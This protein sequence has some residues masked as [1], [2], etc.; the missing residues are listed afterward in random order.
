LQIEAEMIKAGR[1]RG[2]DLGRSVAPIQAKSRKAAAD[3]TGSSPVKPNEKPMCLTAANQK[4]ETSCL[5]SGFEECPATSRSR[6]RHFS[7][8]RSAGPP[9]Q[10]QTV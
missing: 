5:A 7:L 4:P 8:W 10:A 3:Q 1:I 6:L 2:S 9:L